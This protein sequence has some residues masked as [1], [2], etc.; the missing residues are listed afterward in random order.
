MKTIQANQDVLT[1][2]NFSLY[3]LDA[4]STIKLPVRQLKKFV[5]CLSKDGMS[6]ETYDFLTDLDESLEEETEI[7][8]YV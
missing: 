8:L 5:N 6:F 2:L 7:I 3:G 4:V 1:D